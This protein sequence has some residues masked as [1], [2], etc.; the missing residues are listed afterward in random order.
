MTRQ[1]KKKNVHK[2]NNWRHL[3]KRHTKRFPDFP[4]RVSRF[5]RALKS[6]WRSPKKKRHI[7]QSHGAH[8]CDERSVLRSFLTICS[9]GSFGSGRRTE[10]SIHDIRGYVEKRSRFLADALPS[11]PS[12]SARP[13]SRAGIWIDRA[14]HLWKKKKKKMPIESVTT[15][16]CNYSLLEKSTKRLRALAHLMGT[17][18][19]RVYYIFIVHA[20]VHARICAQG[21]RSFPFLISLFLSLRP[22]TGHDAT[23]WASGP[24]GTLP[25]GAFCYLTRG[26]DVSFF[27]SPISFP[28]RAAREDSHHM[29]FFFPFNRA[30]H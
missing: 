30:E 13:L 17:R 5:E 29:F 14:L 16:A 19:R 24:F 1:S 10:E 8:S 26:Q 25:R 6:A 28:S 9:F 22:G 4:R 15:C 23:R 18:V 2:V 20:H 3:R 11:L 27:T 7:Y 12:S 21:L